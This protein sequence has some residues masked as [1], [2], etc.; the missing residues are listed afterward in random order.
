MRVLV[1][2]ICFNALSLISLAQKIAVTV[3]DLPLISTNNSAKNQTFVIEQLISHAKVYDIPMIGF[4]NEFKLYRK[5]ELTEL[6]INLLEKWLKEGF[7]LGNHGYE[8]LNYDN[9][10]TTAYF[11][12]IIKGEK[13]S[14]QLSKKYGFDY[15]YYRHPFLR[16]GN[17][18]EKEIALENFLKRNG[19]LEAPVTVDNS[20][21]IFARAYDLAIDQDD[22]KMKQKIAE[23][24]IP[25]MMDK[26]IHYE[27]KSQMLFDR[28]I[29]Q[30][31]LIHA[32]RINA[33]LL[34]ELAEAINKYGYEFASLSEVLKDPAYL[35]DDHIAKPW[36]ISWID[37]WSRNMDRPKD[38]YKGEPACPQF[39]QDYAG[40]KE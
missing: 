40:L 16:A 33:D 2:C 9:T 36:G 10:D 20:D 12:D 18:P 23:A 29:D 6:K 32:N 8:H 22:T 11:A 39:V 3:D 14:K 25:Y 19:Y 30:V 21:W 4:V 27:G 26:L 7:E 38:F 5:T 35:S 31:L 28:K 17:T 15:K 24:Y 13:V 34:G 37:R 1:I